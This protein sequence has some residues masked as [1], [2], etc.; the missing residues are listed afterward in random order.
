MNQ[1]SEP[2]RSRQRAMSAGEAWGSGWSSV[3]TASALSFTGLITARLGITFRQRACTSSSDHALGNAG[4]VAI[5]RCTWL[6][7]TA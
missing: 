1:L 6:D 2:R 5:T 4:S 7:M 3:V